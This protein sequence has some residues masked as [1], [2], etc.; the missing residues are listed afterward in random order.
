MN[1]SSTPTTWQVQYEP[2]GMSSPQPLNYPILQMRKLRFR[3]DKW[4]ARGHTVN[5]RRTWTLVHQLLKIVLYPLHHGLPY[6]W[7]YHTILYP[8][9][10]MY[11]KQIQWFLLVTFWFSLIKSKLYVPNC[12]FIWR[13]WIRCQKC[14]GGKSSVHRHTNTPAKEQWPDL[15]VSTGAPWWH[16]LKVLESWVLC[17]M[18]RHSWHGTSLGHRRMETSP[19]HLV[20]LGKG[21]DVSASMGKRPWCWERLRAGEGGDRGWDGWMASPTQWTWVWA[22]S[23]RQWT[24]KPGVLQSMGSQ[25]VEQDRATEQHGQKLSFKWFFPVTQENRHTVNSIKQQQ[26]PLLTCATGDVINELVLLHK[27]FIGFNISDIV[28]GT[29]KRCTETQSKSCPCEAYNPETF[30]HFRITSNSK[31]LVETVMNTLQGQII[32]GAERR[33][34]GCAERGIG[35]CMEAT[36]SGM[37]VA[38][39]T[40]RP[41]SSS[42]DSLRGKWGWGWKAGWS[43]MVEANAFDLYPLATEKWEKSTEMVSGITKIDFGRLMGSAM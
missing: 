19:H 36:G 12:Q 3:E 22:N 43:P 25:R 23:G 32:L 4:L 21:L 20:N 28:V 10:N 24:G 42:T 13:S 11:Y 15:V 31:R 39:T 9:S 29:M 7:L 34:S 41:V 38:W 37:L 14:H 26:A 27:N 33:G 5:T 8:S 35:Y 30:S 18:L 16:P 2:C 1:I 17:T 6:Y 40:M